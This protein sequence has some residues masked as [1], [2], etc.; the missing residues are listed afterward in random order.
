[1]K[2]NIQNHIQSTT[3]C[4]LVLFITSIFAATVSMNSIAAPEAGSVIGNQASATYTDSNGTEYSTTSNLVETIIQPV[5]GVSLVEDRTHFGTLGGTVYFPHTLTN[6]G[7]ASDTFNLVAANSTG[8]DFDL[9]NLAVYLDADRD[10]SPDSSEP[11][12][13]ISLNMG[14]EVS[15]ILVGTIPSLNAA[16]DSANVTLTATS[17]SDTDQTI[18]VTDTVTI[19]AGAVMQVTKSMSATTGSPGGVTEYTVI[20]AYQNTGNA[21]AEDLEIIDTLPTGMEYVAGSGKASISGTDLSDASD[22]ESAT[23]NGSVIT[24][25][26]ANGI[27]TFTVDSVSN[28]G[29]VEFNV[30]IADNTAAGSLVNT[31]SFSYGPDGDKVTGSTNSVTFTVS[32]ERSFTL[33]A[34]D[35]DVGGDGDD[36]QK[37]DSTSEGSIV[38]FSHIL[39]N[40]GNLSETLNLTLGSSTY[41]A[42]TVFKLFRSDGVTPLVDT[43]G[44]G[45]LDAG[46]L[47]SSEVIDVVLKVY[48]PPGATGGPFDVVLTAESSEDSNIIDSVTDT[49]SNIESLT[50]DITIGEVDGAPALTG[51][52]VL[53]GETATIPLSIS[54]D[55]GSSDTYDVSVPNLPAGWDVEFFVDLDGNGQLDPGEPTFTNSGSIPAGEGLDILAV[56]TVPEGESPSTTNLTFNVDS[57]NSSATNTVGYEIIVDAVYAFSLSPDNTAQGAPGTS[58]TLA[59][60]LKN[61]GNIATGAITLAL[62]HSNS[63]G[64]NATIYLDDGSTAGELDSGDS[65]YDASSPPNLAVDEQ[66]TL[67]V[68]AI[69]PLSATATAQDAITVSASITPISDTLTETVTDVITVITTEIRLTKLQAL[70]SDCNG[71]I[72][73][74]GF[75][76]GEI[77][78][79]AV[80]GACLVYRITASNDG[81][82]TVTSL[83]V[84]DS[85][86]AFTTLESSI[87]VPKVTKSGIEYTAVGDCSTATPTLGVNVPVDEASGMVEGHICDL[88]PGATGYVEFSVEID[89]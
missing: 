75:S 9:S 53:P 8:D 30:T 59:H 27:V 32:P 42:G 47:G 20:L 72:D 81:S 69:I 39:T 18:L 31:A 76:A 28:S 26:Y 74:A 41:P 36:V 54:N 73:A 51:E 50:V 24:Y 86:P 3:F 58:V 46:L 33:I 52:T 1:M 45:I 67:F 43:N 63:Q 25:E 38:S 64:W 88:A 14:A 48:L 62:A 70:D 68:Q 15:L 11:I 80:P 61:T 17:N 85:T 35:S 13:S 71:V 10:G 78:T 7:N 2:K 57:P 23:N 65:V 89:L 49:I 83:V 12:T 56:I 40:T 60:T 16:A 82:D 55:S 4:F 19:R 34:G 87:F 5:Y 84:Y 21:A 77:S 22:I 44:D 29:Y 79:G 6:T 66:I 37:I